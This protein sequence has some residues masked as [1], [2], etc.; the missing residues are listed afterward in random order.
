MTS[1]QAKKSVNTIVDAKEV[2]YVH[3][4]IIIAVLF[5]VYR[6]ASSPEQ[7]DGPPQSK[8]DIL[9]FDDEQHK[10]CHDNKKVQTVGME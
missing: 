1:L 4:I 9:C 5:T 8:K 6:H 10:T 2:M 7:F 3:T